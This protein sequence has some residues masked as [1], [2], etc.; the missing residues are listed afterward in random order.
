MIDE[1]LIDAL[2][3]CIN[4][5]AAG[6]TVEVCLARYP[7]LATELRPMLEAGV[8]VQQ[9]SYPAVE[10]DAARGRVRRR[11]EGLLNPPPFLT[12]WVLTLML[13][14]LVV[15]AGIGSGITVIR[16]PLQTDPPPVTVPVII[17][18]T[19]PSPIAATV[20]PTQQQTA[21][22]AA[23]Q[24]PTV[25]RTQPPTDTLSPSQTET[26]QLSI[27]GPVTAIDENVITI[28]EQT[29]TL[30]PASP[31]LSVLQPG[32]TIRVTAE[33]RNGEML[34]SSVTFISVEV[35]ID[36]GR[37]WRDS[38]TCENPPPDWVQEMDGGT[39][40]LLRCTGGPSDG[41]GNTVRDNDDDGD[42]DD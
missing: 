12:G 7:D 17:V 1:R 9:V 27:E 5:M 6:E 16:R 20:M 14:S 23:T 3:D 39:A 35:I 11:L 42:D 29:L 2:D 28:F 36:S 13:L 38:G 19:T 32:D 37:V 33:R 4:R 34:V 21:T 8:V 25:T 18:T 22:T 30:P 40:W 10:V 26:V 15:G 24:V 41:G 31:A